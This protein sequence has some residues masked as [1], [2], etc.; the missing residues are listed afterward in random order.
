MSHCGNIRQ[1]IY[2]FDE[3]LTAQHVFSELRRLS[4]GGLSMLE[5]VAALQNCTFDRIIEM[6]GG[7]QRLTALQQHLE[8]L[9]S[10]GIDVGIISFGH[11]DVIITTL[12][13][14]GLMPYFTAAKVLGRDPEFDS[15]RRNRQSIKSTLIS[16]LF[17]QLPVEQRLFVDNDH[18]NME[19]VARKGVAKIFDYNTMGHIV[20]GLTVP[21]MVWIEKQCNISVNMDLPFPL[22]YI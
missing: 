11:R 10:N 5:Q 6:F 7:P 15:Q 17:T 21:Q 12:N 1:V 19:D 22:M 9:T 18:R 13:R 4:E 2:D 14:V 8:Y 20:R 3:T 16:R